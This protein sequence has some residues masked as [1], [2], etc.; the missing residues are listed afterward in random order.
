[1]K[2]VITLWWCGSACN[3]LIT[4]IPSTS[5]MAQIWAQECWLLPG[6]S[7]VCWPSIVVLDDQ[8]HV[9]TCIFHPSIFCKLAALWIWLIHPL[10]IHSSRKCAWFWKK[11][12]GYCWESVDYVGRQW[13]SKMVMVVFPHPLCI[14]TKSFLTIRCCGSACNTLVKPIPSDLQKSYLWD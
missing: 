3:T 12:L 5:A 6:E 11:S 7:R 8:R 2:F 14:N 10:H 1:M 9:A 4:P 13:W